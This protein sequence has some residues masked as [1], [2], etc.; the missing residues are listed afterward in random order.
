MLRRHA[1]SRL[2]GSTRSRTE[3]DSESHCN[4]GLPGDSSRQTD[5]TGRTGTTIKKI[6]ETGPDISMFASRYRSAA[7]PWW[8]LR[9]LP[10]DLPPCRSYKLVACKRQIGLWV[11][12]RST[13]LERDRN[14]PEGC[15]SLCRLAAKR[16]WALRKLPRAL[17]LC[18][19]TSWSPRT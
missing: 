13:D 19:R 18:S 16:W 6:R 3:V 17:P 4:I 12:T 5:S 14:P 7:K 2:T 1:S 15:A 11:L 8:A 9:T 10:R